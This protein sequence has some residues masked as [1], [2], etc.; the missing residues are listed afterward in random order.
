MGSNHGEL[1]RAI[2]ANEKYVDD[3]K[4]EVEKRLAKINKEHQDTIGSLVTKS[5]IERVYSKFSDYA[6]HKDYENFTANSLSKIDIF[7]RE[8]NTRSYEHK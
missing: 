4:V 3:V 5:D 8:D 6:S 1:K 2:T 7:R